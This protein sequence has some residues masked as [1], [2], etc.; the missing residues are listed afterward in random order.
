MADRLDAHEDMLRR[1]ITIAEQQRVITD[2]LRAAIV[3]LR[4]FNRQQ[5]AIN[6]RMEALLTRLLRP[7]GNGREA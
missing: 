1:L 7:G 4:D 5:I 2:D 3:E 6:E